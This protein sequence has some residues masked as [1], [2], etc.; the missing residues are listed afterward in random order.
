M[1]DDASDPVNPLSRPGVPRPVRW[2]FVFHTVVGAIV[3]LLLVS[4]IARSTAI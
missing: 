3:G 2:Y 4:W 1:L